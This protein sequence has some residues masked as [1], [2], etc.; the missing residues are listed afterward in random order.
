MDDQ[1]YITAEKI[2][3]IWIKIAFYLY[4]GLP[5]GHPNFKIKAFSPQKRTSIK[6]FKK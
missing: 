5:K 1:K 3:L 2:C 6:H 4:Q